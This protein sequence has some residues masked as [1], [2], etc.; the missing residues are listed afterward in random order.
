MRVAVRKKF[1]FFAKGYLAPESE[2]HGVKASLHLTEE[3]SRGL[4]L[5]PILLTG[6]SLVNG[7][8]LSPISCLSERKKKKRN[9]L[10]DDSVFFLHTLE[11]N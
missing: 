1:F 10:I 6:V 4:H 9:I 8:P 3:Y 7:G 11:Y 2:G 5:K